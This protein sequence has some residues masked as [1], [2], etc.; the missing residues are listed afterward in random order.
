MVEWGGKGRHEVLGDVTLVENR[1]GGE[2]LRRGWR[3]GVS[4]EEKQE[5]RIAAD[6]HDQIL[7]GRRARTSS[8]TS[9][10]SQ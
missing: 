2:G 5:C 9:R 6:P 7:T 10:V 4:G 8:S 3:R 1:Y